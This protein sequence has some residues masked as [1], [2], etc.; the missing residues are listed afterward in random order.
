LDRRTN[1]LYAALRTAAGEVA[2][3]SDDGLSLKE[4]ARLKDAALGP[5]HAVRYWNGYL[6][7]IED[8]AAPV[9]RAADTKGKN[10]LSRYRVVF[11]HETNLAAIERK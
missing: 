4:V 5:T 1:L 7:V 9:Q 2:V 3:L 8:G 10:R 11:V 6:Y